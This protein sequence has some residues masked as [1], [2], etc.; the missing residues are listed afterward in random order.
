MKTFWVVVVFAHAIMAIVCA[1]TA[2]KWMVLDV[3]DR[4]WQW[5]YAVMMLGVAAWSAFC[6]LVFAVAYL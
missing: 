1:S 4:H 6:A 2:F 5:P 3:E